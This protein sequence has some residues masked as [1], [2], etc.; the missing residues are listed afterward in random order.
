MAI[1]GQVLVKFAAPPR[2]GPA[3][4]SV[5]LAGARVKQTLTRLGWQLIQL[6]A[7]MSVAEGIKFYQAQPNVQWVEPNYRIHKHATPND[8]KAS[9]QWALEKIGA[10]RAWNT[11][12]GT[13]AVVVAVLDTGVDYQ[14]PDLAANI[15][16][17][18]AE[19][20]D[21]GMD[22]DGNGFPD[23]VHGIDVVDMD[24]DPQ[25]DEGHGTHVAGI[26]GAVGNNGLGVT[27]LN[28]NVQ[29]LP[30]RIL[31]ADDSAGSANVAAA[32]DYLIG[33]KNA[34]VNIRVANNSW[35]GDFPNLVVKEAFARAAEAGIL[36]VCSA[37]NDRENNDLRPLYPTGYNSDG[38]LSVAASDEN[39][40]PAS[41]SN[42]GPRTVDL[43]A[44]G[45]N[46]IS[47][48]K[49]GPFYAALS[50]TSAA[51]PLVSGAAA[52]LLARNPDLTVAELKR[53]LL[54]SVDRS[55]AWANKVSSGGRL[56]VA[57]ALDLLAAGGQVATFKTNNTVSTGGRFSLI[58]RDSTGRWGDRPSHIPAIS[59]NG[60]WVAFSSDANNLVPGEHT[61]GTQ[62]YLHDRQ[63][64]QTTR[65]SESPAGEA[66]D[67]DSDNPSISADGRYV[68][69]D[70]T[71]ANLSPLDTNQEVQDVFVWDRLT[72]RCTLFSRTLGNAGANG[73]SAH[74]VISADGNYIAFTSEAT[75]LG[76]SD[77][78]SN[79][80]VFL[81]DRERRGPLFR[82]S[83]NG[84]GRE[85][86]GDSDYPSI[87]DDGRFV[88]FMSEAP[89]VDN[90]D[91]G[92][93]DIFLFDRVG[94]TNELIS[95]NNAGE[96]G[97]EH[98]KLPSIS[99][100]G[101]FVAFESTSANLATGDNNK[102]ADVFL[103]DRLNRTTRRVSLANSGAQ[104]N[105][106]CRI[107]VMSGDGRH[108]VFIS[109]ANN[110]VDSPAS[111]DWHIYDHDQRTGK[112]ARLTLT[113]DG[114]APFG[115]HLY[116]SVSGDGR[117]VAFSSSGFSFVPG[118]GNGVA[119]I[120]VLDRGGSRPDLALR[121]KGES[122]YAGEGITGPAMP[123][124][125][126]IRTP[127]GATAV[128][129]VKLAN[130]AAET[131]AW[132][133]RVSAPTGGWA[134][135]LFDAANGG[136]DVT[137]AALSPAGWLTPRLDPGASLIARL[138]VSAA[139]GN[140]GPRVQELLLTVADPGDPT[141]LDTVRAVTI[142][143]FSPP[144][145]LAVS[146]LPDGQP[147]TE[148]NRMGGISGDGQI[149]VFS[150]AS[151][152]WTA[153]D[154]NTQLDVY[155]YRRD[156]DRVELLS[157]SPATHS[158][159]NGD[160]GAPTISRDG[161]LV[162]F[163]SRADNLVDLDQNQKQDIFVRDLAT[164]TIERVSVALDGSEA[165]GGSQ[166]ARISGNGRF[167]VFQSHASNLTENDTNKCWDI[168]LRDLATGETR[169]LSLASNGVPANAD[170]TSP[171]ISAD[172]RYVL[173]ES[174]ADNLVPGDDNDEQDIFLLDRGTQRL[175]LISR[176]PDGHSGQGYSSGA[177]I[178]DDG[179]LVL[180]TSTALDL[181]A[182]PGPDF[183]GIYL[184]DRQ[185][186]TMQA[187]NPKNN[188]APRDTPATRARFAAIE[189]STDGRSM[190]LV[191]STPGVIP[192]N[193]NA[194]SQAFLYN[195]LSLELTP[196]SITRVG[197]PGN[198]HSYG[199]RLS[200]NGRYVAFRSHAPNLVGEMTSSSQIFV[201]DL[202]RF[203]PS[204]ALERLA[205]SLPG[206]ENESGSPPALDF[207]AQPGLTNAFVLTLANSSKYADQLSLTAPATA[208]PFQLRYFESASGAEITSEIATGA[209][210]THPLRAGEATSLRVEFNGAPGDAAG[211]LA[212]L[213]ITSA[214]DPARTASVTA[215]FL[216][217]LD[218][219]GLPDAWEQQIFGSLA[220]ANATTDHDQDGAS[221]LTEYLN[222]TDALNSGAVFKLTRVSKSL[223]G[224]VLI[225]WTGVS[226][227]LYSVERSTN[228]LAGFSVIASNLPPVLPETTFLDS[229]AKSPASFYRVRVEGP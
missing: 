208:G 199:P 152:S 201:S 131:N 81:Q 200:A 194:I 71:S 167:V 134:I 95:V 77:R 58:S 126:E 128:Y 65:V 109:V 121:A 136:R 73:P 161:R 132:R 133:W 23:D 92:A 22:D 2:G 88:A 18:P 47:T 44:P 37:G 169:C 142:L 35:G 183:S 186:R 76:L 21:N 202:A 146:H 139:N 98:S 113:E 14:H 102:L 144:D 52:L 229:N 118:D 112:L 103:R 141:P 150:S 160:S 220:A 70:S 176:R 157:R 55:P 156:T 90:D 177:S 179:R 175:E 172:G 111:R 219:D 4:A 45:V 187:I 59:R 19:I 86:M 188:L 221:D 153:D 67:G 149:I 26:I 38:I 210:L 69:F 15:W 181:V 198:D 10:P 215:R 8:P 107:P 3:K 140:A 189:I 93:F 125:R 33:L 83:I 42:Y 39:D 207:V 154:V 57:R 31:S 138:E 120:F 192:G 40:N 185:T 127:A 80:D 178:S 84:Q 165:N 151:P 61:G 104:P 49:G 206:P 116:P 51:A 129:E 25:D 226:N 204:A 106:D 164:N 101:R 30:I 218:Q 110:L 74:G 227:R 28:W 96:I 117:W 122:N 163:Q 64:G 41:F 155:A 63:T 16:T 82:V 191:S 137:T 50:G 56:N 91:N 211:W 32:Y 145:A 12:T 5:S 11:T 124:R 46:I 162:A 60:R 7:D 182:N 54:D 135:Q 85:G 193:S 24:G 34:G 114:R 97:K 20:A 62:I 213:L 6:P 36:C 99:G 222:G 72:R 100:D 79:Y 166:S 75:N 216:P 225:G 196:L 168:F 17:N 184:Y 209:W 203:Q 105:G 123:Q 1:P 66:G 43:A 87:S 48:L 171:A 212:T 173:F 130:G 190:T 68:V 170:S 143:P 9:L 180:F 205:D 174:Y 53:L 147:V 115:E 119:D 29:I 89:L 195:R 158:V 217:D 224:A 214:T 94:Q 197:E 108:V 78:N 223:N 228:L 159:G 13:N 148:F 27:G